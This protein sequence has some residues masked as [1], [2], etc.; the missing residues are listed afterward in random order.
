MALMPG[1]V[2]LL[3]ATDATLAVA[4]AVLACGAQ[5][6][7]IVTV[8][9]SFS[10]SYSSTRVRNARAIDASGW[11]K[12]NGVQIIDFAGYEDLASRVALLKPDMCLVA[13]WY[14]MVPRGF[15]SA[16]P[17]GCFGF[18][19][20][21]LPRLRGGAPLNWAILTD[22]SET[23]VT[24]FEM[25]D[26][27]DEGRIFGQVRFPIASREMIGDLVLKASA[28]CADLTRRTVPALLAGTALGTMQD[29]PVSY[30]LQRIPEDGRIDWRSPALAIDRL[31]RAVSRPYPGAST[32]LDEQVVHIWATEPLVSA[33]PVFGAPGQIVRLPDLKHPCVV[34]GD[35]LLAILEAS[36]DTGGDCIDKLRKSGHKRFTFQCV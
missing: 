22:Q 9:E 23:G 32:M 13:G 20:S 3:G 2:L 24:L 1:R 21:L 15:R 14:H 35:G 29:G 34:T 18:H 8:G 11:S 25:T 16:F 5:L 36:D 6:C 28:A 30:G 26:G 12:Q 31:V 7:G 33:P 4:D 19:A 17:R 27:V 10:I